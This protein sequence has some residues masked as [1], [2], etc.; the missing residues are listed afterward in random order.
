MSPVFVNTI[1]IT[2]EPKMNHTEGSMKSVKATF[3][4]RMRK[5][6][7]TTPMAIAVTPMGITSKIHHVAARRKRASEAFPSRES[8]NAFPSGSIAS[9]HGGEK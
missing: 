1:P 6:A 8:E 2:S 3:G 4:S 5:S 9:A 7:C